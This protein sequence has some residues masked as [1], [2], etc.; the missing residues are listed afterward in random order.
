MVEERTKKVRESERK[1]R[2]L[3]EKAHGGIM[4]REG[5]DQTISF[6]NPRMAEMLGYS[7]EELVGKN[8]I[9]IVHPDHKKDYLAKKK[10]LFKSPISLRKKILTSGRVSVRQTL[11]F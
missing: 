8:Y 5:L 7:P 10:R 6:A 1:Y 4:I 9:D 11:H 3:V 2:D